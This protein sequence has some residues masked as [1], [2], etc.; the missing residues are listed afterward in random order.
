MPQ[1]LGIA[2]LELRFTIKEDIKSNAAEM[3]YGT[4]LR[5]AG[6]IFKMPLQL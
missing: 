2:L 3:V 1:S 6:E 4:T 5:L